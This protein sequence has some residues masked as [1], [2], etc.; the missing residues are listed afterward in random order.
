MFNLKDIINIPIHC[1]NL[2]DSIRFMEILMEYPEVKWAEGIN[3]STDR[4]NRA[5]HSATCYRLDENYK[6]RYG[7]YDY[8]EKAATV[9]EI[10]KLEDIL[11]PEEPKSNEPILPKEERF[12]ILSDLL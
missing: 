12:K 5:H 7:T 9:R 4:L 6:L 3:I 1:P 10:R 11:E 8:Y 2:E